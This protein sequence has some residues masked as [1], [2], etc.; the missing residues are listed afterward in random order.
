MP[1]LCLCPAHLATFRNLP[2]L[3][4]WRI[5]AQRQDHQGRWV[6]AHHVPWLL[7]QDTEQPTW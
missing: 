3:E 2:D 5:S 1:D 4:A 6:A 7:H